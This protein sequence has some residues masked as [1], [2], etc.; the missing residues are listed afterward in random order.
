M[1]SASPEYD[2]LANV[3]DLWAS[4]D[5]AYKATHDFYV[6]LCEESDGIIVELGIGTGRI[7]IDIAKQGKNII[8]VDISNSMLEECRLQATKNG[9]LDRIRLLRDDIRTFEI[10][11][12]AD[13]IIFPFRSIGHFLSIDSKKQALKNIYD[14]LAP[15]G[16]FVFDHYIFC[17]PWAKNH[18]GVS[19]LMYHSHILNES[20]LYI[21]DTYEYDYHAQQMDCTI[22]IEKTDRNGVVSNRIHCP[23]SF[24]WI[25]PEQVRQLAI[26]IGFEFEAVYGDFSC[27][28]LNTSSPEQVW[29]FRRRCN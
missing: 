23:L 19:R 17:E 15:G 12:K 2:P 27:N 6:R 28:E 13:L 9:V 4:A 3:Y 22:T 16:R 5:P 7:A 10:E 11:Q 8:G 26:E 18:D 14:Q 25:Y 20:N 24:S 21:W 1:S 29:V